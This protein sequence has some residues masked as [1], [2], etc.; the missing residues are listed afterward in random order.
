MA[1]EGSQPSMMIYLIRIIH[2]S[3][4]KVDENGNTPLHWACYTVVEE[5]VIL[6]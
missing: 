1:A 5:S 6:Y 2:K 4:Q 3:S